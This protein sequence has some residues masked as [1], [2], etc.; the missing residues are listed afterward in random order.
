MSNTL[1]TPTGEPRFGVYAG[2]IQD[3]DLRAYS[4]LPRR[5]KALRAKRWRFVG[6]V[7]PQIVAGVAVVHTGYMGSTFAYAFD[8]S[9]RKLIEFKDISFLA[10]HVTFS[11]RL[12]R[13]EVRY[14]HGGDYVENR[15]TLGKV[16]SLL[17]VLA[18]TREGALE[19]HAEIDED[20][21]RTVPHQMI[22][23]TPGGRV[24]FTHKSAGLPASGRIMVGSRQYTL[25]PG[26]T[27]AAVDHT[28]G[29]HDYHW[30][31]RWASFG[32]LTTEGRRIGLN[33]VDPIHHPVW[34][35]NAVWLDGR[36][37]PVGRASF[38][39]NKTHI[40]APW[41][42]LADEGRIRLQF[43]PLGER[44]ETINTGLIKSAFHQ[45]IGTFSGQLVVN[46]EAVSVEGLP[47]VVEDHT[48]RW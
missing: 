10:R 45:P 40:L 37:Y 4:A 18:M 42:I 14:E 7:N 36:R 25:D 24:V 19:I 3:L 31:W 17:N 5:L 20:P 41:E 43:A 35:E 2:E 11:D 30:E 39:F 13:G 34:Q 23:P 6:L 44:A 28:A 32:G 21:T 33:L 8:L 27:F 48:A 46:G 29:Y 1:F 15:Y 47:G 22:G 16:P 26:E 9:Q 12:D 38:T